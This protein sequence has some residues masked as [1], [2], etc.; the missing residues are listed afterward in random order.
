VHKSGYFK[1]LQSSNSKRVMDTRN[2]FKNRA[3]PKSQMNRRNI[4]QRTYLLCVVF[5]INVANMFAQD[6]II[7]KNG[8]DIQAIVQEISDDNV[9]YKKYDNINGPNYTLKKTE[10][11]M[12][13]YANGSKDVFADNTAPVANVAPTPVTTQQSVQNKTEIYV[14]TQKKMYIWKPEETIYM[15]TNTLD[16]KSISLEIK[17]SR[18]ITSGSKVKTSFSEISDAIIKAITQTYGNLFINNESEVKVILY[19]QAYYATFY[20]G[21]TWF[22]HTRYA[23][24]MGETEEII[25]QSND[26]YNIGGNATSRKV[27]NKSFIGAN[28]SLF[29]F[30]N[31]NL[32]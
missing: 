12:I 3:S 14:N 9:K 24:R 28:T 2:H 21:G 22:G 10:I 18:V 4:M 20:L 13:R 15:R 27:L 16:G 19:L 25:E 29:Q 26:L 6:V 5:C 30:L 1:M 17:D 8:N 11:F 23:V 32:K 31:K 7:L